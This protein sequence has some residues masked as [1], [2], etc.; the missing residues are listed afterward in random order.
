MRPKTSTAL[1][2]SGMPTI[3]QSSALVRGVVTAGAEQLLQIVDPRIDVAVLDEDAQH[4]HDQG[5]HRTDGHG[6]QL[7]LFGLHALLPQRA[8]APWRAIS[9]LLFLLK[10][11]ALAGPPTLPPFLPSS[12]ISP[13][14]ASAALRLP[15]ATAAAF[16]RIAI[17]HLPNERC[18]LRAPR[19]SARGS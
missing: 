15:S 3:K 9:R 5:G 19:R 14:P 13:G 17:S 11:R 6:D 4:H 12:D 1:K 8:A 16:F 10:A 2:T 7:K 18:A